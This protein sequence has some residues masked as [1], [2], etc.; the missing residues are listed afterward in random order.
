MDGADVLLVEDNR[1]DLEMIIEA[2]RELDVGDRIQSFKDGVAALDYFFGPKGCLQ[3][4]P[5]HLPKLI[6]LD[7]KLPKIG[8]LDILKRLKSDERTRFIP[9]I[10][11]T[12]SNETRDRIECYL[13]GAN[14]YVVKPLDADSFSQHISDIR[15]YWIEMNRVAYTE[16]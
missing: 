15:S 4:D 9:T 5:V 2:L 11:F 1:H 13:S 7:L 10:V 8:G 12:S 14:S 3:K 16:Q 6:L